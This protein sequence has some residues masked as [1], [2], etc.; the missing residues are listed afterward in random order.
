MAHRFVANRQ[1]IMTVASAAMMAALL[2]S[3]CSSAP[4]KQALLTGHHGGLLPGM[5]LPES[6]TA[7]KLDHPPGYTGYQNQVLPDGHI[8]QSELF[9]G[10]VVQQTWFSSVG[11]PEKMVVYEAGT[12]PKELYEY[13]PDG[14]LQRHTLLFSGTQQPERI[15]VYAAG[16]TRIAYFMTYW[17]NGNRHIVSEADVPGPNG[18]INRVQEWY[19]DGHQKLLKQTVVIRDFSG[20]AVNELLQDRQTE[21][22]D[23]GQ[24]VYDQ[25]FNNGRLVGDYGAGSVTATH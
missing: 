18:P 12:V 3:G 8:L 2:C 21:W 20:V 24:V 15:E 11:L 9:D 7:T 5:I 16:G 6:A 17:P 23:N 10:L 14:K 13:G 1:K 25:M 19:A 4:P 22:D